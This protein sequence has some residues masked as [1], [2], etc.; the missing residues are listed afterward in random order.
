VVLLETDDPGVLR[1]I[2]SPGDLSER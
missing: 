1:D 2:D